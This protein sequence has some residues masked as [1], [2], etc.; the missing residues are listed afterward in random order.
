MKVIV[1]DDDIDRRT[2]VN[3]LKYIYS[4]CIKKKIQICFAVVPDKISKKD[5]SLINFLKKH[6]VCMHGI[7]HKRDEKFLEKH[8]NEFIPALKKMTDIF[9]NMKTYIPPYAQLS[10]GGI[11]I[12]K[13]GRMNMSF[14]F[15]SY[16]KVYL[17]LREYYFKNPI[18]NKSWIFL[19]DEHLFGY[20]LSKYKTPNE[21]LKHAK[22]RYKLMKLLGKPLVIINHN[23]DFDEDMIDSWNL[24]VDWM[25]KQN[26]EFTTFSKFTT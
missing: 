22:K 8:M 16:Y 18:Y 12:L 7:K 13:E 6:E 17:P 26:T 21:C 3:T 19:T 25:I 24:F 20:K 10:K 11:Y 15:Y 4:K 23:W 2:H 1:R 5:K 14:S 9:G